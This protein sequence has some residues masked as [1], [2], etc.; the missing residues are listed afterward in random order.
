MSHCR[1]RRKYGACYGTLV[2]QHS[3]PTGAKPSSLVSFQKAAAS[4]CAKASIENLAAAV[5]KN[6][7]GKV[8]EFCVLIGN[9]LTCYDN[10]TNFRRGDHPSVSTRVP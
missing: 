9:T 4:A 8:F 6:D 5:E 2:K 3:V 10:L 1:A 7:R